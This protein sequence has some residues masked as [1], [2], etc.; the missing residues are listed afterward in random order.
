MP[1]AAVTVLRLGRIV[2]RLVRLVVVVM[3]IV[4]AFGGFGGPVWGVGRGWRPILTALGSFV[5]LVAFLALGRGRVCGWGVFGNTAR[6]FSMPVPVGGRAG[7]VT[8]NRV[9]NER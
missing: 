5:P 9:I 1:L 2:A 7:L 8:N 3:V 4:A 6:L